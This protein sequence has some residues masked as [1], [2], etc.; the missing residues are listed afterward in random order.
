M[1][2]VSASLR[3]FGCSIIPHTRGHAR[4]P[5]PARPIQGIAR[6]A[7]HGLEWYVIMYEMQAGPTVF[8]TW[9]RCCLACDQI[10]P[11]SWWWPGGPGETWG[12][13]PK[14]L[15][16]RL[17][18]TRRTNLGPLQATRCPCCM[19][20]MPQH[21]AFATCCQALL[22]PPLRAPNLCTQKRLVPFAYPKSFS[23]DGCA[24]FG[25][26]CCTPYLCADCTQPASVH[27]A[28]QALSPVCNTFTHPNPPSALHFVVLYAVGGPPICS[29]AAL[30][31]TCLPCA[32]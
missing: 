19:R 25:G 8:R 20:H 32:A 13:V 1:C 10:L 30:R 31:A 21:K 3:G 2:G 16:I 18:F 27:V 24:L 5:C 7:W 4:S 28:T 23:L 6:M 29:N 12:T 26:I 11:S 14:G 15:G 9:R 22:G 17:H